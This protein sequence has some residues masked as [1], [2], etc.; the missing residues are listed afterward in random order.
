MNANE[1]VSANRQI[2]IF[3]LSGQLVP[4]LSHSNYGLWDYD[5]G[6]MRLLGY[7]LDSDDCT[8]CAHA[9]RPFL[10]KVLP[11]LVSIPFYPGLRFPSALLRSCLLTYPWPLPS[12]QAPS[13]N[14][15]HQSSVLHLPYAREYLKHSIPESFYTFVLRYSLPPMPDLNNVKS[16]CHGLFHGSA[17][18]SIAPFICCYISDI[19]TKPPT[20]IQKRK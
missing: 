3:A 17:Q 2:D 19:V 16:Y 12:S 11:P 1:S 13:L 18:C 15:S 14:S 20:T 5:Y 8:H 4:S 9:G 6:T 7:N 10:L